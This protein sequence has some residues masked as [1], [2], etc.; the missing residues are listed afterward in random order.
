M[1]VRFSYP[2]VFEPKAVQPGQA[3]KYS[4]ML[5]IDK[6]DKDSI[7]AFADAVNELTKAALAQGMGRQNSGGF[8]ETAP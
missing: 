1:L 8:Q 5:L 4:V 6:N 2:N 3:E 7:K